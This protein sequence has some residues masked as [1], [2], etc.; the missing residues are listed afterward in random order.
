MSARM[1][2]WINI[3]LGSRLPS[4]SDAASPADRTRAKRSFMNLVLAIAALILRT[5]ALSLSISDPAALIRLLVLVEVLAFPG[6]SAFPYVIRG[7]ATL[8]IAVPI[9]ASNFPMSTEAVVNAVEIVTIP[10]DTDLSSPRPRSMM[11]SFMPSRKVLPLRFLNA[12]V[13]SG[14]LSSSTTV[15]TVSAAALASL[16]FTTVSWNF[17]TNAFPTFFSALTSAPARFLVAA[18]ALGRVLA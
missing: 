12:K 5:M 10:S 18:Q 13:D 1:G 7:V 3:G 17:A 11:G 9:V 2:V 14:L 6:F 4:A 8:V 16:I 15:V